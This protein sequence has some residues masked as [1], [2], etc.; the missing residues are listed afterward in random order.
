MLCPNWFP[1]LVVPSLNS[2][3]RVA[4]PSADSTQIH[5]SIRHMTDDFKIAAHIYLPQ[6][7]CVFMCTQRASDFKINRIWNRQIINFPS[8]AR[9]AAY[10][11][12]LYYSDVSKWCQ[13]PGSSFFRL[14]LEWDGCS[15]S[16]CF[17]KHSDISFKKYFYG[18]F[19]LKIYKSNQDHFT[20]CRSLQTEKARPV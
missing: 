12:L 10:V 1:V 14:W 2:C 11:S 8:K 3:R 6:W 18:S 5:Q 7:I 20:V 4:P 16:L 17:W 9:K 13:H 19:P 15:S